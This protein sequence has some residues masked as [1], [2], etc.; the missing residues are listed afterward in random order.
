MK[1][2]NTC[3]GYTLT[4]SYAG[5]DYNITITDVNGQLTMFW[6]NVTLEISLQSK[7]F[8]TCRFA[9]DSNHLRTSMSAD[10]CFRVRGMGHPRNDWLHY[11]CGRI[12]GAQKLRGRSF[13]TIYPGSLGDCNPVQIGLTNLLQICLIN[14]STTPA[15]TENWPM[16][17]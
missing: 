16:Q 12:A 9:L 6:L 2:I 7:T 8:K 10:L 14:Q 15:I 11:C 5:S 3:S 17:R 4:P 1:S 13:F